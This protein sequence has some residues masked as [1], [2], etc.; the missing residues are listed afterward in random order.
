VAAPRRSRRALPWLP[1]LGITASLALGLLAMRRSQA[2]PDAAAP[3]T[4]FALEGLDCPVWCAVRLTE[5]VDALP[6]AAVEQLDLAAQTLRV[7]HD[8][9]QDP[10]AIQ[11]RIE[12]SGFRVREVH[13]D[14]MREVGN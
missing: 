10:A 13:V 12:A 3:V 9:R 8:G 7:R 1:I 11:R 14:P 6:G 4:V 2:Q 5:G